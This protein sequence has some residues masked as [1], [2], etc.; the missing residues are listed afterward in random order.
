MPFVYILL[1]EKSNK[2]YVGSTADLERRIKEHNNENHAFTKRHIP[3]KLFY[4]EKY[5]TLIEAR[6]REKYLKSCAGR[7][8]IKK[9]FKD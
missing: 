4:K 1:S 2:T 9:L 3:W 6:K 7:K 8:F 5:H